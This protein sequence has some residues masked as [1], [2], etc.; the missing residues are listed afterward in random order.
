M[1]RWNCWAIRPN[2][3]LNDYW[4]WKLYKSMFIAGSKKVLKWKSIKYNTR[5]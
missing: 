5:K 1:A 3:R 2:E 4:E